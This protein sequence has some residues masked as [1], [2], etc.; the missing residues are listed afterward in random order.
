MTQIGQIGAGKNQSF[1]YYLRV[2]GFICT[3]C[4]RRSD[5]EKAPDLLL[6]PDP[7]APPIV[8]AR[9][10]HLIRKAEIVR[11]P[12]LLRAPP[13]TPDER[14]D[15]SVACCRDP[16]CAGKIGAARLTLDRQML[17]IEFGV[18]GEHV[19]EHARHLY[20]R[21]VA[22]DLEAVGGARLDKP[23]DVGLERLAGARF[24]QEPSELR[25]DVSQH[26]DK[27]ICWRA[28]SVLAGSPDWPQ[29]VV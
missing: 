16:C 21:C 24:G 25:M 6:F 8:L 11:P 20:P 28:F 23:N 29:V 22:T 17:D 15:S 26:R 18:A 4:G 7:E 10:P 19:L 27:A 2:S 3:I 1:C 13:A 9:R 5:R 12:L 14:E